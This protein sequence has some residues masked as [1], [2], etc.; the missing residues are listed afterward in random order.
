MCKPDEKALVVGQ[1]RARAAGR[2]ERA[3]PHQ[4][5]KHGQT[6]V[7]TTKEFKFEKGKEVGGKV[8]YL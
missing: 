2:D 5:K 7:R 3:R 6:T 4:H 8:L 1:M